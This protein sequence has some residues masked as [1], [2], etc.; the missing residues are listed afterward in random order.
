MARPT[1]ESKLKQ[2]NALLKKQIQEILEK[3]NNSEAETNSSADVTLAN[4]FTDEER[5]DIEIHPNKRIKVYSLC[6]GMMV[7]HAGD[8]R[9]ITSNKYQFPYFGFMNSIKYSDLELILQWQPTFVQKGYF[10]IDDI[11]VIYNHSLQDIYKQM[12]D[13]NT[14]KNFL[15][16]STS[17]IKEVF[18]KL[19]DGVKYNLTEILANKIFNN[20]NI[21]MNKVD[22]I[23]NLSGVDI[24]QKGKTY[25]EIQE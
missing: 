18:P 14:M 24:R 10:Y 15:S 17:Q 12:I 2:E 11:N 22:I 3:L 8:S 6:D 20:E 1:N 9:S 4:K 23:S 16:L 7:L 13:V 5:T 21:D 19:P 25:H